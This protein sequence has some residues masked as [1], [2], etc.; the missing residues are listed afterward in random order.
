M[1]KNTIKDFFDNCASSWDSEMIRDDSIINNILD[2]AE[3]SEGKDVLDVACGTGV[4]FKDYLARNVASITG[5][6]ISSEML[7]YAE[8]N[9]NDSRIKLICGDIEQITILKDFD[10]IVIYNAFPH[11]PNP[12]IVIYNLC[13]MLKSG[14]TLTVAHG[15]SISKIDEHHS[16]KANDVSIKLMDVDSLADLFGK[17]LEVTISISDDR[18]YQVVGRKIN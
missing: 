9:Y 18:M 10:N 16:G 13:Q 12:E 1:D 14:G 11:F 2:N 4:L 5:V 15:M 8:K 3:V 6:D 17:Y 7:K